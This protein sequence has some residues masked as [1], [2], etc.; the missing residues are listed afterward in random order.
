M[1]LKLEV[2][3]TST[4]D[5][6]LVVMPSVQAEEM[7]LQAYEAGYNAGWEDA[8]AAASADKARISAELA[9]NLQRLSFS[10][11]EAQ[12]Q[13]LRSIRP[14]L[15]ELTTKLL[16]ELA[17]EAIAPV[18]LDVLMPLLDEATEPVIHIVLNPASRNA[19]EHLLTQAAGLSVTI[20]EEPTLGEG[21]VYLRLGREELRVDLD[22]A[23]RDI[24][25][26]VQD[27]FDLAEKEDSHG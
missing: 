5:V 26:V 8:V 22:L 15:T 9:N 19:V 10:Y 13:V 12:A 23:I 4:S 24:I 2:F 25:S 16:P 17:R 11:H 18:V 6:S 20:A 14:L 1:A 21:Q 27:F 3:E 7:R